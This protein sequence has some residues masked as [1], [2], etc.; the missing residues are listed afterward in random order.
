MA[1]ETSRLVGH[2]GNI[3]L[4]SVDPRIAPELKIQM[5]AFQKRLKLLGRFPSKIL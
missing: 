1:E 2:T 5:D 3:V 4:V